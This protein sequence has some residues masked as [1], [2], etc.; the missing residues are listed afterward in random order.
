ME[1]IRL[2]APGSELVLTVA[3]VSREEI[4]GGTYYKFNDGKTELLVPVK[5]ADRQF[6]RVGVANAEMTVG[7]TIRFSRSQ[8]VSK[9]GHPY[10]NLDNAISDGARKTVAAALAPI[11]GRDYTPPQFR[12][13]LPPELRE[14]EEYEQTT[15]RAIQN[16]DSPAHTYKRITEWVLSDIAPMY[17]K[18]GIGLSPEAAAACAASLFIQS[19][20]K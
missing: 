20:K 12:D 13:D 17:E 8:E 19:Q 4:G 2:D 11:K 18:A 5:S 1:R 16:G 15:V 14:Q 9:S 7:K 6:E 3:G 10:W